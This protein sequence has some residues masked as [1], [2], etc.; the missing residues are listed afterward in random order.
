MRRGA[1]RLREANRLLTE[2]RPPATDLAMLKRIA[3]LGLGPDA[4]F[5]PD[6]FS[7]PNRRRSR[8][9]SLRRARS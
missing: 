5:A 3:P 9:A 7:P 1:T 6:K 2:H 8:L 4:Q